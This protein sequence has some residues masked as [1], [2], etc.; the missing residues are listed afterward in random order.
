MIGSAKGDALADVL[1]TPERFQILLVITMGKP[2]ET[3]MIE[4]VEP[5]EDLTYYRDENDVHHVPKRGLD[6]LILHEV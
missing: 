2:V 1:G 5:G 4:I 6:E 3:V